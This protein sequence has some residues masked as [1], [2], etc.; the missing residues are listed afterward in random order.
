MHLSHI[1]AQAGVFPEVFN[2]VLAFLHTSGDGFAVVSHLLNHRFRFR[3]GRIKE[4]CHVTVVGLRFF[5]GR[6]P[7]ETTPLGAT[8]EEEVFCGKN[9]QEGETHLVIGAATTESCCLL[10]C[11]FEYTCCLQ[12]V[13]RE[14]F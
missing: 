8:A 3:V 4:V 11:G 1:T 14:N 13:A 7:R 9:G 2:N 12:L 5:P 6:C 10:V